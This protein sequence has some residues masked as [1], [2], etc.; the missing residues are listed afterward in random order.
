ELANIDPNPPVYDS[1]AMS[2]FI[3]RE[4]LLVERL[5][6]Q[7]MMG[8]S[9]V[10][11]TLGVL[12][13]Y[14]V[15][16]YLVSQRSHEIGIRIAIGATRGDV[17]RLILVQGLKLSVAGIVIG[18][19]LASVLKSSLDVYFRSMG[20]ASSTIF[21]F[22]TVITVSLAVML[23]ACYVPARRASTVDP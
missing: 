14:G 19:I 18:A 5:M 2:L 8:V 4:A 1:S 20:S 11:L 17:A 23:L 16:A 22:S 12:G 3:R 13:L 9:I 6:A 10:G 21:V 7:V 15:I